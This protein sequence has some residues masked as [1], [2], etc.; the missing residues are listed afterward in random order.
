LANFR[1]SP[2]GQWSWQAQS[3]DTKE[4]RRVKAV[5]E[6]RVVRGARYDS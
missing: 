1:L 6:S 2:A 4:A 3:C 5:L